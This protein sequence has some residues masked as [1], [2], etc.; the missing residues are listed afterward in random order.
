MSHKKNPFERSVAWRAPE[1]LYRKKT[2]VWYTNVSVFFFVALVALL[3]LNNWPGAIILAGLF[4]FFIAHANDHPKTVDYKV[5]ASGLT[6]GDRHV[7]YSEI[8]SFS[9]DLSHNT[10]LILLELNYFLALPVTL[11]VKKDEIEDVANILLLHVPQR[12]EFSLIRWIT[13]WLHY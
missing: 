13:H 7:N 12:N 8:S 10:P 4:W 5:D 9:L 3:Y 11:L 1:F 2:L 6:V